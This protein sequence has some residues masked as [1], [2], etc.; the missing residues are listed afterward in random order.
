MSPQIFACMLHWSTYYHLPPHVLPS[1]QAVE[2][3]YPGSVHRNID[4]SS[5]LG[6]MQINTRWVEPIASYINRPVE[7]VR[8]ELTNSPCANVATAAY[9]LTLYLEEAHGDW[10]QAIGY[11]HSHTPSL[12][13]AY[14]GEVMARASALFGATR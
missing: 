14:R 3:G 8:D 4:G 1:I 7:F 12:N 6:V 9:I 10:M 2:G 11:Y 13:A 5:D